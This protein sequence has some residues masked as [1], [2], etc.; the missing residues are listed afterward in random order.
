[1]LKTQG[2]LHRRQDVVKRQIFEQGFPFLGVVTVTSREL[3]EKPHGINNTYL[4]GE[5]VN[6]MPCN[7]TQG[8]VT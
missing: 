3:I 8:L 4:F 6:R 1:M 7:F 5:Q 2:S